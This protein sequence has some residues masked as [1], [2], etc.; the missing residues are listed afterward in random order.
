VLLT[1]VIVHYLLVLPVVATR[2]MMAA[3]RGLQVAAARQRGARVV[4]E[5]VASG[6]SL[7]EIAAWHPNFAQV[8]L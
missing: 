8:H 4:G 1:V 5:P 6:L 2:G 7:D 3:A